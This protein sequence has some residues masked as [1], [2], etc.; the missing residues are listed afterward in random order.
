M[1]LLT[2]QVFNRDDIRR[3]SM[4]CSS[5][6][7]N[8]ADDGS[9]DQTPTLIIDHRRQTQGRPEDV[10]YT[11]KIHREMELGDKTDGNLYK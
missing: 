6:E 7:T 2:L 4:V 8:I 5:I 3:H 10:E 1:R 9:T 11:N